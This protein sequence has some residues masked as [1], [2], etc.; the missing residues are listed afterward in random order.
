MAGFINNI[1]DG[2]YD[3]DVVYCKYIS[4][5]M[6]KLGFTVWFELEQENHG[7]VFHSDINERYGK[8]AMLVVSKKFIQQF[9]ALFNRYFATLLSP[10]TPKK[11]ISEMDD[12]LTLENIWVKNAKTGE[13]IIS[14]CFDNIQL[15]IN[16][17]NN[18]YEN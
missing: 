14:S 18:D 6:S 8:D 5:P 12:V 10:E 1:I 11:L 17:D 7:C 15:K 16:F 2:S 3:R 9:D 13:Y 4:D